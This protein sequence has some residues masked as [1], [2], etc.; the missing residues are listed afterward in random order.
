MTSYLHEGRGRVRVESDW[1]HV[2]VRFV[3][4][5]HNIHYIN[6]ANQLSIHM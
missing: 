3:Q 5:Q 4:R 1:H 2:S 6:E